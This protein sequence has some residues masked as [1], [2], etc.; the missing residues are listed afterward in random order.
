[1]LRLIEPTSRRIVLDGVDVTG[2]KKREL[3]RLRPRTSFAA[4]RPLTRGRTLSGGGEWRG[5]R[6]SVPSP[7]PVCGGGLQK[8]G[9]QDGRGGPRSSGDV[10]SAG[11]GEFSDLMFVDWF[12]GEA[13]RQ[14]M[15]YIG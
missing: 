9:A 4:R 13:R 8:S 2:L 3:R 10:R 1:M 6:M 15:K 7:R 5:Q 14:F 12:G 11:A